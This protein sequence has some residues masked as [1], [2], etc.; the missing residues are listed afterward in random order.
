MLSWAVDYY[1]RLRTFIAEKLSLNYKLYSDVLT[2][3][4]A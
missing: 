2:I 3:S 1:G 4:G